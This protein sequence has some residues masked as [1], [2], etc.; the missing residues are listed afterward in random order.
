MAVL[1]RMNRLERII[2]RRQ[3]PFGGE[4]TVGM[5][6]HKAHTDVAA[7]LLRGP[8]GSEGVVTVAKVKLLG[9]SAD[10]IEGDKFLL[11][12]PEF[13]HVVSLDVVEAPK[14][15]E[16]G[17]GDDDDDDDW[18]MPRRPTSRKKRRA[19]PAKREEVGPASGPPGPEL[20]DMI[21]AGEDDLLHDVLREAVTT[22]HM[23]RAF[24]S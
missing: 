13:E 14:P 4:V 10:E 16:E 2:T 6:D 8:H 19:A 11:L 1:L 23:S 15:E 24:M 9:F 3:L 12:D 22:Y 17:L 20:T 7:Q 18:A 5:L 21:D